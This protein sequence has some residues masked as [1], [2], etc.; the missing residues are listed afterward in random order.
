MNS[1][2][3]VCVGDYYTPQPKQQGFHESEVRYALAEGGCGG[4]QTTAPRV[5]APLRDHLN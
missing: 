1:L 3:S 5:L 4:G 2:E